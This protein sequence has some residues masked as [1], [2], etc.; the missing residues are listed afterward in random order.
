MEE[1]KEKPAHFARLADRYA[2]PFTLIAYLIG[3]V[4]WWLSKDL[5]RFAEVLVVVPPC[6]LILATPIAL[7]AGMSHASKNGII[8][9]NG[10]TIEELASTKIIA[11]DKTGRITI[12]V[13]DGVND[14]STLAIADVGI[15]M[16][17]HVDSC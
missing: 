5:L 8:V 10:M 13:G 11:F 2:I 16:G 6:P 17:I 15:A 1:S 12:M 3:G 4:S 9:K 7:V 14:V